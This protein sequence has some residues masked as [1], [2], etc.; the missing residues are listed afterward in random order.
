MGSG[1][2]VSQSIVDALGGSVGL[3]STKESGTTFTVVLPKKAK[4][5]EP[6]RLAG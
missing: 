1:F 2:D 6:T 5:E 3:E 4:M